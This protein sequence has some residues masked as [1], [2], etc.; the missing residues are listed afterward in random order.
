M[1]KQALV[2]RNDLKMSKGKIAGQC[3]HASLGAVLP[4]QDDPSVVA[5]LNDQ[6]FTKV[7]LKC[8]TEEDMVKLEAHAIA[9]G[10][11]TCLI[12]DN[13]TTVF[14][15]VPTHTVLAIGPDLIENIDLVVGHL[16]LL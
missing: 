7:C 6:S 13:G 15:G 1:Y 3:A 16:K 4:N 5:W 12:K 11:I 8:D 10:M 9:L 14:N 2:V